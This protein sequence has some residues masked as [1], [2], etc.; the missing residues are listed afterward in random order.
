[1]T[2]RIPLAAV[3][4]HPVAHSRSPV[5]HGHWLA[6]YGIAG[7]YVPIDVAPDHLADTLRQLP[8]LGFVGANVTIPH[9]EAARALATTSTDRARAIGAANTLTFGADGAVHADN[10]DG[11]GFLANLTAG[12]LGWNAAS[13]PALV[14]GAGG[15]AR[16]I[17]HALLGSGLSEIR[18][19][20][21]TRAKAQR[22]A[23]DFGPSIKVIDWDVA[24]DALSDAT[25]LVNTTAL[26]M[27]GQPPLTLD[28][29]NLTPVCTV[30]DIVYIPLET[31]LLK[32]ARACGCHTVDGLG[33]L[34][35]QAAQGFEAWFGRTPEVDDDLRRAVLGE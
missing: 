3:L 25:L 10:T 15:A 34:L 8:S 11:H 22:L 16:G 13:G 20:N 23:D 32:T 29:S 9:K 28:L 33:M 35:H 26:G 12:A 6:R 31:E 27:A 7:H 5:L 18:L 2:N 17:L 21:R 1:M 24:G 19:A 30:T 4:G 14:L